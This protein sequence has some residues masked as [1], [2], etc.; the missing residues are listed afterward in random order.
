MSLSA[1]L[2]PEYDQEC[3]VTRKVL[4]RIPQ[5]KLSWK[6]GLTALPWELAWRAWFKPQI[7]DP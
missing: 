2:L 4:T 1:A 5:D 6:E 3:A 7:H